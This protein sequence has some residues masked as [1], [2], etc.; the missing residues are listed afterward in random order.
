MYSTVIGKSEYT[1]MIINLLESKG[2]S[3]MFLGSKEDIESF[4]HRKIIKTEIDIKNVALVKSMVETH[5]VDSIFVVT[6]DDRL[7]MMLAEGL[8]N[9]KDLYVVFKDE[10]ILQ[11]ADGAYKVICLGHIIRE[12]IEREVV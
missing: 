4:K 8:K 3:I 7:N 11:I 5:L 10:K 9:H 12:L 6:N 1:E 2:K